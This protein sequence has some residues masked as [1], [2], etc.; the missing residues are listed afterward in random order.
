MVETLKKSYMFEVDAL[1][2]FIEFWLFQSIWVQLR[3]HYHRIFILLPM[4][5]PLVLLQI[6]PVEYG[7]AIISQSRGGIIINFDCDES[8]EEVLN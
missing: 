6:W 5:S 2:I 3:C 4:H 7:S 1:K 8:A